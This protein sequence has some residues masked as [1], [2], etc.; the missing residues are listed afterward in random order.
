MKPILPSATIFL[1]QSFFSWSLQEL[2]LVAL[3]QP[4]KTGFL[5]KGFPLLSGLV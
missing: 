4:E 3:Q 2:P 1:S 5:K